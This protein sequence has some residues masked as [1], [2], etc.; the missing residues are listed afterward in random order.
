MRDSPY[1]QPSVAPPRQGVHVL[2]LRS[3]TSLVVCQLP[4]SF[5]SERVL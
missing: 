4:L 3:D 1:N 2:F 5:F